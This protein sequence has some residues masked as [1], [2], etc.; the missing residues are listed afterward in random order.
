MNF[1]DDDFMK[2]DYNLIKFGLLMFLNCK[3][4]KVEWF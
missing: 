2:L 4:R 1:Y 3:K